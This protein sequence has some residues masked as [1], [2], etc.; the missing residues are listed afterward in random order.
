MRIRFTLG[1][2]KPEFFGDKGR[3][4]RIE[5]EI[6]V[7]KEPGKK[8]SIDLE[9]V[10]EPVRLSISGEIWRVRGCYGAG[11]IWDYIEKALRENGFKRLNIPREYAEKL[12]EIWKEWHLNDVRAYCRHQKAI[13]KR[14]EKENPELL[15][16]YDKLMEIPELKSCPACGHQYGS[17]WLYE[18]LPDDV[19]EFLTRTLP[20]YLEAK[21]TRE[22]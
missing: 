17:R 8:L 10:E 15:G 3:S 13:I 21:A 14:I 1:W 4:Y 5:I 2:I 18:P 20:S 9:E 12:I 6:E 11:Q 7:F 19:L 22:L 16:D